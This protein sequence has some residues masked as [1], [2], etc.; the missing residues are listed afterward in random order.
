MRIAYLQDMLTKAKVI[1]PTVL[2]HEK[3]CFGSTVKVINLD[4]EQ[5]YI[6]TIVGAIES[7]PSK[8]LV[9][10]NSPIS[11]VLIGKE[12]GDTFGMELPGGSS[13]IEVVEIYYKEI[14]FE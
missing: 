11:R 14:D 1:D 12:E 10:F 8:G 4:T 2:K 5:E 3:V 6:Y 7:N 13:E 9:S